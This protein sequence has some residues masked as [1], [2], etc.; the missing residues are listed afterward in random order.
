MIRNNKYAYVIQRADGRYKIGCTNNLGKRFHRLFYGQL[1][2]PDDNPMK[3]HQPLRVAYSIECEKAFDVEQL[4][5]RL[6]R[7]EY[8]NGRAETFSCTERVAVMA[9]QMAHEIV[10]GD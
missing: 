2:S 10:C 5:M 9:V 4:A 8:P 7:V 3:P 1:G 6:L